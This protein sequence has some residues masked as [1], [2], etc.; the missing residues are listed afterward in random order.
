[1]TSN[2]NNPTHRCHLERQPADHGTA[3]RAVC[4]TCGWYGTW[5]VTGARAVEEGTEHCI[6]AQRTA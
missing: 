4:S 3:A 1:M 2:D 5:F 6:A